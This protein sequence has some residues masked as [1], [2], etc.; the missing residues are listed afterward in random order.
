MSSDHRL[1]MWSCRGGNSSWKTGF[2]RYSAEG[3]KCKYRRFDSIDQLKK[4]GITLAVVRD[5]FMLDHCLVVLEVL[6]HAIAVAD[7]VT[8][9]ELMPYEKFKKMWRFS[10]IVLERNSVQRI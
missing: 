3:L 7:P 10:G 1:H 9:M 2:V 5:A 4:A 8:G 6:D